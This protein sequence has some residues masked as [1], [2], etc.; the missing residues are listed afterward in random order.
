MTLFTCFFLNLTNFGYFKILK[1]IEFFF[2][3]LV[4]VKEFQIVEF[5]SEKGNVDVM[6]IDFH[7]NG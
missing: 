7:Q 5:I 1:V 4:S 6:S 2:C 3:I